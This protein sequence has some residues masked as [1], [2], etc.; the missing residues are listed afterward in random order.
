MLTIIACMTA[1][2][3]LKATTSLTS[4]SGLQEENLLPPRPGS[5][6]QRGP[7]PEIK[8]LPTPLPLCNDNFVRP[9]AFTLLATKSFPINL[10]R[11]HSPSCHRFGARNNG[12]ISWHVDLL[13][14]RL[15]FHSVENLQADYITYELCIAYD[16]VI[17]MGN[18]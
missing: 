11:S 18:D 9:P 13:I 8:Y 1:S 10:S 2:K 5:V 15:Q 12:S 3:K 14:S 17:L 4:L 6:G 16:I 7:C